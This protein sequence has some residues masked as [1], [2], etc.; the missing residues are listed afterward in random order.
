VTLKVTGPAGAELALIAI[1]NSV[2]VAVIVVPAGD[3]VAAEGEGAA[4]DGDAA[5]PGDDA[6]ELHAASATTSPMTA[7]RGA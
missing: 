7:I 1:A 3:E 5:A 4:A 6:V 2:S